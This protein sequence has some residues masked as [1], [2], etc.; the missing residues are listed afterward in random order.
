[1]LIAYPGIFANYNPKRYNNKPVS[2]WNGPEIGFL[3]HV[4]RFRRQS[5]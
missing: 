4:G 2:T 3:V 5:C 1:M